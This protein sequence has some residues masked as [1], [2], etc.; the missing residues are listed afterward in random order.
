MENKTSRLEKE[1][2]SVETKSKS[3][4]LLVN[5]PTYF[6]FGMLFNWQLLV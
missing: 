2:Q 1:A 5:M 6:I 4:G 3:I